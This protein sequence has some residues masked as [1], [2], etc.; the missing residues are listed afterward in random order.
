MFLII[1]NKVK[2]N[3]SNHDT[4]ENKTVHADVQQTVLLYAHLICCHANFLTCYQLLSLV[5]NF[6]LKYLIF[7]NH[8]ATRI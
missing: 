3:I 6:S 8:P 2:L 1:G 7:K 4:K 5:C